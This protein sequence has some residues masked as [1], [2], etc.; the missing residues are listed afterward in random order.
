MVRAAA[1]I[2]YRCCC[3]NHPSIKRCSRGYLPNCSDHSGCRPVRALKGAALILV[4]WAGEVGSFLSDRLQP[5]PSASGPLVIRYRAPSPG[6][7]QGQHPHYLSIY[8]CQSEGPESRD[9]H[10]QEGPWEPR[11]RAIGPGWVFWPLSGCSAFLE[12]SRA[13]RRRLSRGS[14][15]G[16]GPPGPAC[17]PV[18]T[19]SAG[20]EL[21]CNSLGP[22][23]I[24]LSG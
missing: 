2:V 14:N 19:P 7:P 11:Q 21:H 23:A 20:G 24:L 15:S 13:W 18:T 8:T 16:S 6:V 12:P 10:G 5:S 9:H 4:A 17:P 22:A 3:Y 1:P